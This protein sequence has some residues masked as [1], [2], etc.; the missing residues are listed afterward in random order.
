MTGFSSLSFSV[1]QD[2][3][4][5][6]VSTPLF[7]FVDLFAGIGGMR[8]GF[9]AAGGQCIFGSERDIHAQKTYRANYPCD[10]PTL[11]GDI[12]TI[13]SEDI[14]PH[15][16]LLAGFPCQPFSL[17]GISARK[18]SGKASGFACKSQGSL[19]FEIVRILD[20]H[21]PR[22]FL[23]ENVK[24]LVTHDQGR[25]W[26]IILQ[27]LCA[28]LGYPIQAR[29]LN[30]RFWV[31]QNRKRVFIVGFR[32]ETGFDFTNISLPVFPTIPVLKDILH[33]EDGSEATEA[34]YTQG[35]YAVVSEHYTLT[36]ALWLSFQKHREK[37]RAKGNGFGF[38]LCR[39]D[40]MAPTL[41]A[42]YAQGGSEILIPQQG[43][44]PRRLTP[45]ECSRLMGFDAPAES[46]FQIPVSDTQAYRQFGNA[47]VVPV[48]KTIARHM[49]PWIQ[50]VSADSI[51]CEHP[52][53]EKQTRPLL[54][55]AYSPPSQEHCS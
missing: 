32:E 22:A 40:G 5:P 36:D 2:C 21:R 35:K 25:T 47:V 41:P 55:P 12:T 11:A 31:P 51:S 29:V 19:F 20:F 15:D 8:K 52:L 28:D 1:R 26:G 17:A 43:K 23:L 3:S 27:T 24:N 9:E 39:P 14:P 49:A 42:H 54:C 33:P 18:R 50:G 38:C 46:Q 10:H 37:H 44:N 48:V 13:P 7:T 16:V 30:A 53:W 4:A 45:R 6:C 34:P